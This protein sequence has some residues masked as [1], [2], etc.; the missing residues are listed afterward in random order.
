MISFVI[1]P[2]A[3]LVFENCCVNKRF[4]S[5]IPCLR[6][7]SSELRAD[8]DFESICLSLQRSLPANYLQKFY[9][10]EVLP[11]PSPPGPAAQTQLLL[12]KDW[13]PLI[14]GLTAISKTLFYIVQWSLKLRLFCNYIYLASQTP[15]AP[16]PLERKLQDFFL[17]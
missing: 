13:T 9:P 2:T 5:S 14:I 17:F 11:W 4:H 7:E 3:K 15:I 10:C 12:F 1:G 6:T 8:D 16:L